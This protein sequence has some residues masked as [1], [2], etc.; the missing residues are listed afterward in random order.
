MDKRKLT[1]LGGAPPADPRALVQ[2]APDNVNY[3]RPNPDGTRKNCANCLF[4]LKEKTECFLHDEEIEVLATTIC[5][6]HVFGSPQVAGLQRGDTD[7]L[8]PALS[9][10]R[11]APNG[12]SCDG[13]TFFAPRGSTQGECNALHFKEA[14]KR[15]VLVAADARCGRWEPSGG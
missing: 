10:L 1:V 3:A 4:W 2:F 7:P 12:S 14:P 13:C 5:N 11:E 8:D 6:Y 9:G 15:T